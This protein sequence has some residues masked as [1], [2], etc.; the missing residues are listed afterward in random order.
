MNIEWLSAAEIH[1]AALM[2]PCQLIRSCLR[3]RPSQPFAYVLSSPSGCGLMM[4]VVCRRPNNWSSCCHW[5]GALLPTCL[6]VL[7]FIFQ[8]P[9]PELRLKLTSTWDQMA[10]QS[11]TCVCLKLVK[12]FWSDSIHVMLFFYLSCPRRPA[13]RAPPSCIVSEIYW[14]KLVKF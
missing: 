11:L 9:S 4:C 12:V 7:R 10:C 8:Q 5:S 1:P 2:P 14:H 13:V 3:A 6:P